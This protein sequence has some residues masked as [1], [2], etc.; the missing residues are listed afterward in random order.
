MT[1]RKKLISTSDSG[2]RRKDPLPSMLEEWYGR[3]TG[4]AETFAHLPEMVSIRDSIEDLMKAGNDP[5]AG[6]FIR[7]RDE[8]ED[9]VGKDIAEVTLPRYMKDGILYVGVS[10]S[11]WMMELRS[12]SRKLI[13]QNITAKYGGDSVKDIVFVPAG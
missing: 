1:S 9:I 13:V 6:I 10:N 12:C 5:F 4:S 11:A 3:E 8:W 2:W 7:I